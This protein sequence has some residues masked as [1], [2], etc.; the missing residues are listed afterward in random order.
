M[1]RTSLGWFGDDIA[2]LRVRNLT[3]N[4]TAKHLSEIFG[5]YGTVTR[6]ECLF[7][8]STEVSSGQALV[9][10]EKRQAAEEALVRLDGAQIDGQEIVVHFHDGRFICVPYPKPAE[11][12]AEPVAQITPE[13]PIKQ[14]E[15]R[16]DPNERI[17]QRDTGRPTHRD[18]ERP[19]GHERIRGDPERTVRNYDPKS[20]YDRRDLKRGNDDIGSERHVKQRTA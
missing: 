14:H 1:K 4:V 8:L 5:E 15:G 19:R 3:R 2:T 6:A 10:F 13:R 11:P 7:Y 12:T 20:D 17:V 16:R 9:Q 18:P